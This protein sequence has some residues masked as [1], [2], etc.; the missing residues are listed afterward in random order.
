MVYEYGA[1]QKTFWIEK[2]VYDTNKK[3]HGYQ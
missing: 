2:I 3:S 1:V